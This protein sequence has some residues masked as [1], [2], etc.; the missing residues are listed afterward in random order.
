MAAFGAHAAASPIGVALLGVLVL[1]H[2]DLPERAP[3][4]DPYIQVTIPPIA[5]PD[6]TMIL[7]TGEAPM[8]L[9]CARLPAGDPHRA[10][11]RLDD[12]AQGRLAADG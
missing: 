5:H 1:T 6:K 3:V 2:A 7:M 8:G 4:G 11:R 9:S 10:H 12:R